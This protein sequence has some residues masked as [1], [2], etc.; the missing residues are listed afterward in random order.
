MLFGYYMVRLIPVL[1]LIILGGDLYVYLRYGTSATISGEVV[2]ED[3]KYPIIHTLIIV[4]C[5]VLIVHLF[6]GV[7]LPN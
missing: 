1:L 4:F 3:R 2:K 7:C 6:G 5:L